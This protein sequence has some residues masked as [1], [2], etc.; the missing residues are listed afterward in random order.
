MMVDLVHQPVV[1]PGTAGGAMRAGSRAGTHGAARHRRHAQSDDPPPDALEARIR[2]LASLSAPASALPAPDNDG[3]G[4]GT[5]PAAAMPWPIMCAR[6]SCAAGGRRWAAM[7]RAA[8]RW[9]CD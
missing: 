9:R 7:R 4:G 1:A 3:Y 6:R 2:G 8:R 5:A